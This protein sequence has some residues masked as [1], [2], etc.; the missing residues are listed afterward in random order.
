[1]VLFVP[2]YLRAVRTILD[3]CASPVFDQIFGLAK[4]ENI[5][6]VEG[7]FYTVLVTQVTSSN[8]CNPD[9]QVL[10]YCI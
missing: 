9:P 6:S 3:S 5:C 7:H 1:M 10:D 4:Y 8:K 2:D